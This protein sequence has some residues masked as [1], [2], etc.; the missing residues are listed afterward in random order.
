MRVEAVVL[1]PQPTVVRVGLRVGRL[2]PKDKD[3]LAGRH[4]QIGD[5]PVVQVVRHV[6]IG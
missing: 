4:C 2:V 6:A 1:V 3:V 5:Q